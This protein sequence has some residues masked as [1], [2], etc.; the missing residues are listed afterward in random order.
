MK[1]L[2]NL[3]DT[4]RVMVAQSRLHA[5]PNLLHIIEE[6]CNLGEKIKE[7]SQKEIRDLWQQVNFPKFLMKLIAPSNN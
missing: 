3:Q 1:A 6:L 5:D 7:E 2:S 4:A